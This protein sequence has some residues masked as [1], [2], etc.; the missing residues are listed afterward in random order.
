MPEINKQQ[1]INI[2]YNVPT[3]EGSLSPA[4]SV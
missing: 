1:L 2:L 4:K 3:S